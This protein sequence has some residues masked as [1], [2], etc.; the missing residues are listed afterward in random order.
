MT[1]DA[2]D[3]RAA[4]AELDAFL[5]GEL[6]AD[7]AERMQGHLEHCRHCRQ[8]GDYEQAFRARLQRL[9]DDAACPAALRDRITTLL[10]REAAGG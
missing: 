6:P 9:R 2:Y 4:L 8:I 3:C 10:A 1:Q 5:Q 7:T